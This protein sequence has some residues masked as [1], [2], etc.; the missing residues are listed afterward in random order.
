VLHGPGDVRLEQRPVPSIEDGE[1][2]V[3]VHAASICGT[4]RRILAH[5]HFKLPPGTPRVL[6]H[7]TAGEVVEVGAGVRGLKVGDRVTVTPNVGCGRCRWCRHGLN[8]MCPDYEAFGVTLD[9]GFQEYL[10][11]PAFALPNVFRIPDGLAFEH[12]AL[13]EPFSCCVRG[14]DALS[15]GVEDTVVIVGA[16]PIG[17]FHT[18]LARLSGARRII[19]A[20]RSAG[21]LGA[22]KD[23]GADVVVAT[24][25]TDLA[26][27]VD[28]E[29]QGRGA[30]VVVTCASD[31]DVQARS[32]DLLGT[33]GRVN[34]FSGL[35]VGHP[36][37]ID[38]NKVHYRGITL[39]GTT[40]SSNADY[41]KAL[42][43]LGDG[44]IS[45]EGMVS[46]T[47][48]LEDI[49]AALDQAGSG[50]GLKTMVVLDEASSTHPAPRTAHVGQQE[51]SRQEG[52]TS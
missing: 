29:T 14:L 16:G 32:V 44:V 43:L 42:G 15:V 38:T 52:T 28:A 1:L 4:D 8:N 17:L 26:E 40:G 30:D 10:R 48:R 6:G 51:A 20:N 33:H 50:T 46:H 27:V 3:R 19:V 45:L 23:A 18:M 2:L 12:A 21:R 31:P 22:A 37:P 34:F 39:T 13:A 36:V 25:E 47:F 49:H 24:S 9:G 11:V 5:G 35:G 7:E 41:E